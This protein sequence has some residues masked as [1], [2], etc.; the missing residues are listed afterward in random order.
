MI[1][2]LI[3]TN[4][5]SEP[6]KKTS[7]PQVS[8]KLQTH[9]TEIATASIVWHELWFGCQRLPESRRRDELV[10]YLQ[11]LESS[12]LPTLPYDKKASLWHAN[13]R[14]R[15][16]T[17]GKTPSF[18]DSQIAAIAASNNLILVTRNIKDFEHFKGL[19]LENWFSHY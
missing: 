10:Q 17:I 1:R 18:I 16:T 8:E 15:L 2:F 4:T 12:Q 19:E 11:S 14:T 3:D 9:Q 13:E 7:D 5:L 6:F